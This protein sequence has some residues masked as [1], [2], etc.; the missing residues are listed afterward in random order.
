MSLL[1][2]ETIRGKKKYTKDVLHGHLDSRHFKA[3]YSTVQ[4]S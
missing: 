4:T 3:Y 1:N 2:A